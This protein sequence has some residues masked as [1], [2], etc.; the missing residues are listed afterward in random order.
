MKKIKN[1]KFTYSSLLHPTS[2][3]RVTE[4]KIIFITLN[5]YVHMY[6]QVL[7]ETFYYDVM[8]GKFAFHT[9]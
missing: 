6:V 7:R 5:T 4:F 2:T 9:G 1:K 8:D 3:L